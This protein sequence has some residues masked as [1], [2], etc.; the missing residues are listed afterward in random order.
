LTCDTCA[1]RGQQPGQRSPP[2]AKQLRSVRARTSRDLRS[3]LTCGAGSADV[4]NET[5]RPGARCAADKSA[6]VELVMPL[7][8]C[9][10]RGGEGEGGS[11]CSGVES[12]RGVDWPVGGGRGGRGC[13]ERSLHAGSGKG[14]RAAGRGVRGQHNVPQS[15]L[16]SGFDAQDSKKNRSKLLLLLLL[17]PVVQ[18]AASSPADS[19]AAAAAFMG[20]R[21]V[22]VLQNTAVQ[23][24]QPK[25]GCVIQISGSA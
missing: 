13:G 20:R 12:R 25:K 23:R 3:R 5:R 18:L 16:H 22:A 21:A 4:V 14:R 2:R 10:A 9:A 24:T 19:A 8:P 6:A 17:Q 15:A 1:A 11:Q 7:R